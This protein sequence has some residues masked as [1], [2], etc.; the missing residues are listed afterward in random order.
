MCDPSGD[1]WDDG[2]WG[3]SGTRP[4]RNELGPMS[5]RRPQGVSSTEGST[6][7]VS[8]VFGVETVL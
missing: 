1:V 5:S 4:T 2:W 6:E 8:L 3:E 7:S